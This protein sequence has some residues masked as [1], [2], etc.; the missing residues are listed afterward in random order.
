MDRHRHA[1]RLREIRDAVGVVRPLRLGGRGED[2][3]GERRERRDDARS[4][5][6][7]EHAEHDAPFVEVEDSLSAAASA[8][9]PCGLWAASTITVGLTPTSWRRPGEVD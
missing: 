6:V 1:L 2:V 7:G 5:L 8:R 4:I 3:R 9:A